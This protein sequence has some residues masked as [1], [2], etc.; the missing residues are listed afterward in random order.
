MYFTWNFHFSPWQHASTPG[1]EVQRQV[2][3][4]PCW[5]STRWQWCD[6]RSATS[7]QGEKSTRSCW[8][9]KA[10]LAWSE[11]IWNRWV[12]LNPNLQYFF[13]FRTRLEVLSP[14]PDVCFW[15]LGARPSRQPRPLGR[16]SRWRSHSVNFIIYMQRVKKKSFLQ[17]LFLKWDDKLMKQILHFVPI[18]AFFLSCRHHPSHWWQHEGEVL[19]AGGARGW[20]RWMDFIAFCL[21]F[22]ILTDY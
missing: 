9:C 19:M 21:F 5:C 7:V 13:C 22:L 15:W 16:G 10:K 11:M 20:R 14:S 4:G 12:I 8:G 3:P 2:R 17:L 6:R 18:L 1:Q